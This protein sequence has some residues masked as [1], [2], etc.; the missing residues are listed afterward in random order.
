LS[1]PMMDQVPEEFRIL[2]NEELHEYRLVSTVG[3]GV[4]QYSN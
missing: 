2:H 1:G 3:A 4:T